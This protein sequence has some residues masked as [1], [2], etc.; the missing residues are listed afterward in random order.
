MS[1]ARVED[2]L[3]LLE[4]DCCSERQELDGE[5]VERQAGQEMVGIQILGRLSGSALLTSFSRIHIEEVTLL[6]GEDLGKIEHLGA[7][8]RSFI[9]RLGG[10]PDFRR[11]THHE[12]VLS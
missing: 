8:V 6:A 5:I 4:L 7:V 3:V 1:V 12:P 10:I 2:H 9:H 11:N